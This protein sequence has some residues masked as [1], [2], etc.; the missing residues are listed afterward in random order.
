MSFD[1]LLIQSEARSQKASNRDVNDYSTRDVGR[2]QYPFVSFFFVP[3]FKR[4]Y[5]AIT[6]LIEEL[7][8]LQPLNTAFTKARC[9]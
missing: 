5:R 9:S 7:V 3:M 1:E 2:I 8:V 6:F 4:W